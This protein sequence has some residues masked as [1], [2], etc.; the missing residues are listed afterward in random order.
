MTITAQHAGAGVP[1]A[2]VHALEEVMDCHLVV[3]LQALAHP[4]LEEQQGVVR[5]AVLHTG[6]EVQTLTVAVLQHEL[7]GLRRKG[8]GHVLGKAHAHAHTPH[9]KTHPHSVSVCERE[10]KEKQTDRQTETERER[11]RKWKDAQRGCIERK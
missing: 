2:N 5:H 3:L 10:C 9:K 8:G 1:L 7:R 11:E 6:Q 4:A